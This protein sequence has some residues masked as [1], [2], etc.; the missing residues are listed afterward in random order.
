MIDLTKVPGAFLDPVVRVVET[1]LSVT[2]GV[3]PGDVMLAGAWYRDV[4]HRALGHIFAT[5]ATL[6]F[7]LESTF[8]LYRVSLR[9]TVTL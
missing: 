4:M 1:A 2:D 6:D 8:T 7:D 3:S 9:D 5:T